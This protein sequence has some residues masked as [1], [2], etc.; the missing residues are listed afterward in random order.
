MLTSRQVGYHPDDILSHPDNTCYLAGEPP[1]L[2]DRPRIES[3]LEHS[4]T[5]ED[6][7]FDLHSVSK[8]LGVADVVPIA[9]HHPAHPHGCCAPTSGALVEQDHAP[10]VSTLLF[11]V[12]L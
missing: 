7:Q 8:L 6:Y 2:Q 10:S 1:I 12:L 4:A 3:A 9:L 5:A 11:V